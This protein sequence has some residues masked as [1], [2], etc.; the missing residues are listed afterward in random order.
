VIAALIVI[1]ALVVTLPVA[2]F[3]WAMCRI[4]ALSDEA[5]RRMHEPAPKRPTKKGRR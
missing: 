4:A 5:A 1:G 2:L 3:A